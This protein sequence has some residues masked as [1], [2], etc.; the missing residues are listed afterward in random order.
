MENKGQISFFC[1]W[2]YY[3]LILGHFLHLKKKPHIQQ[4]SL[5]ICLLFPN[6]P[7]CVCV[8]VCVCVRV[9]VL[10]CVQLFAILWI[11]AHKAPLSK[12]FSKQE[13]WEWVAISY[14][15]GSSWP[16]YQ[17]HVSC[18]PHWQVGS[19]PPTP[20]RKP[21]SFSPGRITSYENGVRKDLFHFVSN[22]KLA[23]SFLSPSV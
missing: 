21:H 4:Q 19:L 23:S 14:S 15:R 13:H 16:R 3:Y 10:R 12:G 11:V 18:F 17:S 20:P 9:C 6:L 22:G 1:L 8:C 5:T 7:V 2:L